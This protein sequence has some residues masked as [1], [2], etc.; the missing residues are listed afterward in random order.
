MK[1]IQRWLLS[2][3]E[4]LFDV[5]SQEQLNELISTGEHPQFFLAQRAKLVNQRVYSFVLV[6]ALCGD[7]GLGDFSTDTQRVCRP[8]HSLGIFKY[9]GHL[10]MLQVIKC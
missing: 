4:E 5:H 8:G 9:L 2:L 1:K 10:A 7:G 6:F 3:L